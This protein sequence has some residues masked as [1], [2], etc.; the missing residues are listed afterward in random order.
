MEGL[1][2]SS[3]DKLFVGSKFEIS[4]FYFYIIQSNPKKKIKIKIQNSD[5]KIKKYQIEIGISS[6]PRQ[7]YNDNKRKG[8]K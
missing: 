2:E 6:I 5:S 8:E 1:T 4:E 3:N 7:S